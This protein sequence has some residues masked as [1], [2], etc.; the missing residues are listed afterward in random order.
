MTQARNKEVTSESK[1]Q[2]EKLRKLG[3]YHS[4]ELPDGQVIQGLIPLEILRARLDRFSIPQDLRGSR[5]L[6][7]GAWDGWFSFEMERRGASVLAIDSTPRTNF[8]VAKKLLSSKVE[9]RV[10]DICKLNPA[11]IGKFD[12]VL[13]LGVLYHLKHPLL[14][15]ENICALSDNMACLESYVTD[16][17]TS[18][19]SIPIM[20]FYEA[21]ELRGQ[22]DNW[23]GPNTECFLSFARTAGFAVVELR[24]VY[25]QRAHVMCYRRW[26]EEEGPGE[27]PFL[28]S[29]ENSITGDRHFLTDRD[30]YISFWFKAERTDLTCDN[31]LA[32]VGAYATRPVVVAST[33]KHG[34]LA[35]CKLPPGLN[36]AYHEAKIR[37]IDTKFSNI[38]RVPVDDPPLDEA[39]K[40]KA[41]YDAH[42]AAITL[43]TDGHSWDRWKIYTRLGGCLSIWATG[44]Q[45][46]VS[47]EDII[48]NIGGTAL[49]AVFVS[50]VDSM[51]AR[52]VNALVPPGLPIGQVLLYL[53]IRGHDTLPVAVEIVQA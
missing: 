7:I 26:R 18:P 34:W 16:D 44:I 24:G 17:G 9:H 6:D 32:Q 46:D 1:L 20:E 23:V 19:G 41:K 27:R 25:D 42:L 37:I 22:F 10:L 8:G 21:S 28:E 40:V 5:V 47:C 13:F 35:N 53:T 31:V 12:I 49:G 36:R 2:E 11:E 39:N 51:Q 43:V 4:I 45:D 33:G 14:A 29:A 48:I 15:L 3:W 50:D 30:D 38:I 52:Q